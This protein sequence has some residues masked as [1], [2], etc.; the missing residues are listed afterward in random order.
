MLR[1]KITIFINMKLDFEQTYLEINDN[2]MKMTMKPSVESLETKQAFIQRNVS[3]EMF[4]KLCFRAEVDIVRKWVVDSGFS[5]DT[6]AYDFQKK[7][8]ID[9]REISK[10]DTPELSNDSIVENIPVTESTKI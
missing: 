5:L 4:D 1:A 7:E 3:V 9:M 8:I 10:Q 6:H 2:V